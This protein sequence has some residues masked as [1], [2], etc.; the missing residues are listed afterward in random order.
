LLDAKASLYLIEGE[1][2]LAASV[3]AKLQALAAAHRDLRA[4]LAGA[5]R[6]AQH[7]RLARTPRSP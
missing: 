2:A 3:R 7:G 4:E 6:G 1:A 5:P